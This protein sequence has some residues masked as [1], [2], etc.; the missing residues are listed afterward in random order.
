MK[1]LLRGAA[2][3]AMALQGVGLAACDKPIEGTVVIEYEEAAVFTDFDPPDAPNGTI[4]ANVFASGGVFEAYKIVSIRNT[5]AA[6]KDFSF[7]PDK[8]FVDAS[9]PAKMVGSTLRPYST[10]KTLT[11]A[12][13]AT[14]SSLGRIIIKIPGDPKSLASSENNLSYESSPGESVNLTRRAVTKKLLEPG[15]PSNLP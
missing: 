5:D 10:L 1:Y 11:V 15:T 7:D 8:V 12:K 13:G 14:A 9:P 4:V 3:L 2:T 6:A